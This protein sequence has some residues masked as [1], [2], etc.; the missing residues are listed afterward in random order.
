MKKIILLLMFFGVQQVYAGGPWVVGK[1]KGF[2]QLQA[3]IPIGLYSRLFHREGL[4]K[5]I[6][7]HRGV[8]DTH[9]QAYLEYGLTDKLTLI[10][11]LP[12]KYVATSQKVNNLQR[13]EFEDIL[14]A[15]SLAALGNASLG[16]KQE[17]FNKKWVGAISA[18]YE[19]NTSTT[20]LETGLA[21]GYSAGAISSFFHVGKSLK[22]D[23]Y[24]FVEIGGTK[25][26]G[27]FSDEIQM[28]GEIGKQMGKVWTAV[29]LDYKRSLRNGDLVTAELNQ[30]GLY[31]N[32]QEYF[33]FG[34]KIAKDLK[35]K[36]GI[37]FS[38]LGAFSGHSVAH[39]A[40]VNIGWYKKW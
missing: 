12:F 19:F 39:L 27:N 33:A 20:D 4:E 22:K 25:R 26:G 8:T 14:E 18:R 32:N 34:G 11:Q 10:S 23:S 29:V 40:S 16:L 28:I 13:I 21:T 35:N 3:T 1:K 9:F 7:L 31:T 36:N 15:G 37:N 2:F 5:D 6:Y 24:F 38:A 17:L 30:T